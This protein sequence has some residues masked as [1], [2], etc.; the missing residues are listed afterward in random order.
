[1][2]KFATII[3]KFVFWGKSSRKLQAAFIFG[4][5]ARVEKYSDTYSDIDIIMIVDDPEYFLYSNEWLEHIGNVHVSFIENSIAGGKERRIIFDDALD[6]DFII[7]PVSA[8]D[9]SEKIDQIL[10]MLSRGYR[11]LIDKINLEQVLAPICKYSSHYTLPTKDEF[12]NLINDFWFHSVWTTKKLLRGEL[13]VAKSCLDNYM[14]QK[15]LSMIEYHAHAI[16]GTDYNT[17]HDGRFLD[18]WADNSI[19]SKLPHTFAH[20]VEKI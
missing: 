14:K 1:M 18:E 2:S 20:Y 12:L 4:S 15:L 11:I 5:Q 3:N 19:T 17:W 8:I 9:E 16:N 10:L 6:V 7:L 13:W